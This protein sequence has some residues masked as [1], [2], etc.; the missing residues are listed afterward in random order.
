MHKFNFKYF[1]TQYSVNDMHANYI[2]LLL[3]KGKAVPFTGPE[4][5]RGFLE[6][7]QIS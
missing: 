7:S 4:W 2:L 3:I 6:G 1:S 5:P